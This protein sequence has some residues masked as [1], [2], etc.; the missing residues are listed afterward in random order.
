MRGDEVDAIRLE[1]HEGDQKRSRGGGGSTRL[2]WDVVMRR[3]FQE[4]VNIGPRCYIREDERSLSRVRDLIERNKGDGDAVVEGEVRW[5]VVGLTR[6]CCQLQL[7][8]AGWNN[9]RQQ[10]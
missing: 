5:L 10:D 7:E 3:A 6:C 8:V 9:A 2:G 1:A 4:G